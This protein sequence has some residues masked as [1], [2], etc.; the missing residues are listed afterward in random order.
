[1]HRQ[2]VDVYGAQEL[3][4]RTGFV[5]QATGLTPVGNEAHGHNIFFRS[6]TV[7]LHEVGVFNLNE[8]DQ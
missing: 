8:Q 5:A 2:S 7:A 1:M 3:E 6:S 4:G